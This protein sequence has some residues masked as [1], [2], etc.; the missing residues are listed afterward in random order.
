MAIL[1]GT[2]ASFSVGAW[3]VRK[4]PRRPAAALILLGGIVLPLLAATAPP[5]TSDDLYRYEWDGRVQA[6]ERT[7]TVRTSRARTRPGSAIRN[8]G[9]ARPPGA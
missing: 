7:C 5:R 1:A 9:P 4:L 6:A 2:S 3:L 8:C